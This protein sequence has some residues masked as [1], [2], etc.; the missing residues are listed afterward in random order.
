MARGAID[1]L[2]AAEMSKF[3]HDQDPLTY[4]GLGTRSDPKERQRMAQVFLARSV[5]Q[6][7][8]IDKTLI[9]QA[10]ST[11]VGL[12]AMSKGYVK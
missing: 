6:G 8:A 12:K 5:S 10:V 9:T 4:R 7:T 1:P 2:N 11:A 3:K